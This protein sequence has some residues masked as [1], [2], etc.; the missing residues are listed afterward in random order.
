MKAVREYRREVLSV[1][2]QGTAICER[3]RER[4][5]E[6]ARVI[7][8]CSWGVYGVA[9]VDRTPIL[10]ATGDDRDHDTPYR[11]VQGVAL[12]WLGWSLMCAGCQGR[13]GALLAVAVLDM[14][15]WRWTM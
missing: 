11:G 9:R 6:R 1:V 15:H 3:E 4:E 10:S 14:M 2:V 13:G 5:G 8:K 7:R 12:T